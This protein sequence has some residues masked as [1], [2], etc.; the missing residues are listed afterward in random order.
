[1]IIGKRILI[2]EDEFLV[3]MDI[4][5]TLERAGCGRVDYAAT[6][7]EALTLI[8]NGQWD[9]AIADG[10]LNGHKITQVA[11]ALDRQ[12]I[13]FVVVTGYSH[14][15]LPPE[16]SHVPVLSKPVYSSQIIAALSRLCSDP[17]PEGSN[18]EG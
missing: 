12:S 3:A 10:N 5:T 1:V 7:R 11:K 15:S 9:A 8:E 16:V 4:R 2:I 14:E 6:E 18:P 13:P 17:A